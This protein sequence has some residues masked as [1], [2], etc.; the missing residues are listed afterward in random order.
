MQGLSGQPHFL[1][2]L[3]PVGLR[4]ACHAAPYGLTAAP[5]TPPDRR[6]IAAGVRPAVQRVRTCSATV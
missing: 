4:C 1:E 3:H 6:L 5:S 2:S